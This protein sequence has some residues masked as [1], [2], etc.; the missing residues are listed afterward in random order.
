[1]KAYPMSTKNLRLKLYLQNLL[2]NMRTNHFTLDMVTKFCNR[3]T[4][5]WSNTSISPCNLLAFLDHQQQRLNKSETVCSGLT[6]KPEDDILLQGNT[7]RNILLC[8]DLNLNFK[9]LEFFAIS[10]QA[11]NSEITGFSCYILKKNNTETKSEKKLR[12][13][14]IFPA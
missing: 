1:M 13:K 8:W 5:V 3:E 12:Q 10:L 14:N 7:N 6:A 11:L 2:D 9:T 4:K